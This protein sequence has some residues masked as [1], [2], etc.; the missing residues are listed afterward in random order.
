M[1]SLSDCST[2][3]RGCASFLMPCPRTMTPRFHKLQDPGDKFFMIT[4]GTAEVTARVVTPMTSSCGSRHL[5]SSRSNESVDSGRS[6][7]RGC[8]GDS[9]SG[10]SDGNGSS[11]GRRTGHDASS[12]G[13]WCLTSLSVTAVCISTCTGVTLC[14]NASD[15]VTSV[16]P[17]LSRVCHDLWV[18]EG[19]VRVFNE[20]FDQT[21]FYFHLL[22]TFCA[23]CRHI[24][25]K[26]KKSSIIQG[27]GL[28]WGVL[29]KFWL[30][31]VSRY[32]S[33]SFQSAITKSSRELYE[34]EFPCVMY[35]VGLIGE[36]SGLNTQC[37]S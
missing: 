28:L 10:I 31:I 7:I 35:H 1:S 36:S 19:T 13:R 33:I 16:G 37:T 23:S 8:R 26:I 18:D 6:V 20:I 25:E 32:V 17:I 34:I 2:S 9:G 21:Y 30:M 29:C 27:S 22:K 14:K 12:V 3:I 15:F 24:S 4:R 11:G 5:S